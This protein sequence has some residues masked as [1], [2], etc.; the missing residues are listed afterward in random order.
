MIRLVERSK[1]WP[2]KTTLQKDVQITIVDI[3]V[4]TRFKQFHGVSIPY[5]FFWGGMARP[6]LFSG[7]L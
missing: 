1:R 2:D 5:I 6:H 7:P 4:F 3:N